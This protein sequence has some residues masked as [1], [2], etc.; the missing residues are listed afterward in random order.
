MLT[1][2]TKILTAACLFTALTSLAFAQDP[3]ATNGG[4]GTGLKQTN[5]LGLLRRW[6][7]D[8][9]AYLSNPASHRRYYLQKKFSLLETL[10]RART[11]IGEPL[12]PELPVA[13]DNFFSLHPDLKSK[14][15]ELPGGRK[16]LAAAQEIDTSKVVLISADKYNAEI[17]LLAYTN[18][19]ARF[20]LQ[21]ND[22]VE[23]LNSGEKRIVVGTRGAKV[24]TTLRGT[25]ASAVSS[26]F[27]QMAE[28]AAYEGIVFRAT[29]MTPSSYERLK[30][31]RKFSKARFFS[32]TRSPIDLHGYMHIETLRAAGD[33]APEDI[34]VRMIII[35]RTGRSIESAINVTS[36]EHEVLFAPETPF[37]VRAII[38]S[39]TDAATLFIEEISQ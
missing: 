20:H 14:L 39:E 17:G 32:T 24:F 15:L 2:L 18:T 16:F 34:P 26:L 19:D 37:Y 11:R 35:S 13:L 38:E 29:R 21:M 28:L 10:G 27:A 31:E 4:C 30:Q 23:G 8:K 3:E 36:G 25:I 7:E 1:R 22:Y 33:G 6:S 12:R 9:L 5:I